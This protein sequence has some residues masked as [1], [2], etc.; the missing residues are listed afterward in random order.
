MTMTDRSALPVVGTDTTTHPGTQ[1]LTLTYR[2]NPGL[3]SASAVEVQTS[4]DLKTWSAPQLPVL[5]QQVGTAAN[6]DPMMEIGMPTNG[7][8]TMFIRMSV[9]Q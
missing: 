4:T 9:R 5:S 8:G 7:A 3:A 6:G 2:Q 1:Y